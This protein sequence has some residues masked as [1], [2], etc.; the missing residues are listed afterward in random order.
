MIASGTSRDETIARLLRAMSRGEE[1]AEQAA[2]KQ[3][4]SGLLPPNLVRATRAQARQERVHRAIFKAAARLFDSRE[5]ACPTPLDSALEKLR[6]EITGDLDSQRVFA[7]FIGVQGILEVLGGAIL[8]AIEAGALRRGETFARVHRMILRQE[9]AHQTIGA[10]ALDRV[11][12]ARER[13]MIPEAASRY[14]H[15]GETIL[16]ASADV[17][18]RLNLDADGFMANTRGQWS[19]WLGEAAC[20]REAVTGEP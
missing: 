5:H 14:R 9:R 4:Q 2:S 13:S 6:M 10:R 8:V 19:A 16:V 7:T 17:A 18:D 3:S 12:T 1:I 11:V 20:W 15:L